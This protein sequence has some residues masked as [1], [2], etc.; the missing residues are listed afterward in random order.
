MDPGIGEREQRNDHVARP[1]VKVVLEPL[2]CRDR[3]LQALLRRARELRRRLLPERPSQRRCPLEI[4]AGGGYALVA[5]PIASPEITGSMPD[6]NIA[7]Q[8]ATPSPI[9]IAPRPNGA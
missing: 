3:R 2:V 8:I 9:E 1:R 5:S 4:L 6:L 7:T